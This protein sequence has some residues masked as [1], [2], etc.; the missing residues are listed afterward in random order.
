MYNFPRHNYNKKLEYPQF[1]N[2]EDTNIAW[3]YSMP[4]PNKKKLKKQKERT[5]YWWNTD[6]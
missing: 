5:K 6:M 1:S 4:L 2:S 3:R